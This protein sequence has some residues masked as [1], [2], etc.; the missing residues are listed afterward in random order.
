MQT[1]DLITPLKG[2]LE[3][4][5]NRPA[6]LTTGQPSEFIQGYIM[7]ISHALELAELQQMRIDLGLAQEKGQI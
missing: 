4:A 1:I 6:S 2:I 3:T 5:K 7:A